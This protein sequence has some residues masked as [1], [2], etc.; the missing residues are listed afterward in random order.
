MRSIECCCYV[1]ICACFTRHASTFSLSLSFAQYFFSLYAPWPSDRTIEFHVAGA[2]CIMQHFFSF[3]FRWNLNIKRKSC[4]RKKNMAWIIWNFFFA[5]ET[6]IRNEL[7][8]M[9]DDEIYTLKLTYLVRKHEKKL[10]FLYTFFIRIE[11]QLNFFYAELAWVT[12]V[13]H[14]HIMFYPPKVSL[15]LPR[16]RWRWHVVC[17]IRSH[18]ARNLLTYFNLFCNLA[19]SKQKRVNESREKN[20][21]LKQF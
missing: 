20:T 5:C 1:R 18:G 16:W 6:K 14:L 4:E 15:L 2:F 12:H 21:N 19:P 10:L 13:L 8:I 3:S 7:A 11:M 9:N 17:D